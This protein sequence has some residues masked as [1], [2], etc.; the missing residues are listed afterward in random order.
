MPQKLENP[1]AFKLSMNKKT[2]ERIGQSIQTVWPHFNSR[3]FVSTSKSLDA[4]ELKARVHFIRDQ[5]HEAL[6]QDYRQALKILL[7]SLDIELLKGF[8]LWPY[9][10]FVQTYGLEHPKISL[11]ALK[12]LTTKFTSEFAVRPFLL[13]DAQTT[14][15]YL[16]DCA[17]DDDPHV[18]RWASEG[19]RPR[20]P[21]GVRLDPFI[22]R[23]ESTKSILEALKDD[24]SM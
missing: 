19:S 3:N 6:P 7:A 24:P 5:L 16:N 18:R 10:E 2:L 12:I 15:R 17:L 4:L 22:R 11:A 8:D 20:L 21:W 1:G 13:E 23:P 14:L 9:T